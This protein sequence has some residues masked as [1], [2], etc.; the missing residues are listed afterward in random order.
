MFGVEETIHLP[1]AAYSPEVTRDVYRRLGEKARVALRAGHTVLLDATFAKGAERTAAAEAAA[2][3]SVGFTGLFLDAPYETRLERLAGRQADA[4]DAD[5]LV[6]RGQKAEPPGEKGWAT[7]DAAK[8]LGGTT[9]L[10]RVRLT[11]GNEGPVG[12]RG[13]LSQ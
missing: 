3:V 12:A 11:G 7:L 9:M 1:T 2:Q 8:D 6:A 4:S 13:A 10:A 5:V